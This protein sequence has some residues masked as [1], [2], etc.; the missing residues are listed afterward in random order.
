MS[1]KGCFVNLRL[2]IDSGNCTF[3]LSIFMSHYTK[4]ASQ[5]CLDHSLY[6]AK[7][8]HSDFFGKHSL[9]GQQPHRDFS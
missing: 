4:F 7:I 6:G 8:K 9:V 3:S 2:Q 1:L 5:F